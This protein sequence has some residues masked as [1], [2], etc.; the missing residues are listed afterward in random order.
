M[1]STC[2]QATHQHRLCRK[3][4]HPHHYKHR[5]QWSLVCEH[6]TDWVRKIKT[7]T[8]QSSW[9]T[10]HHRLLPEQQCAK[11]KTA[12]ILRACFSEAHGDRYGRRASVRRNGGRVVAVGGRRVADQPRRIA[13]CR[14][15]HHIHLSV[16]HGLHQAL[17][18]PPTVSMMVPVCFIL[19]DFSTTLIKSLK[20]RAWG[21]R[22]HLRDL[23]GSSMYQPLSRTG[24]REAAV[25][26]NACSAAG[27]LMCCSA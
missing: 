12:S 13:P 27:M 21:K 1:Q 22:L 17:P 8:S 11:C 3:M 20:S 16:V 9:C 18:Q 6:V 19:G 23:L 2:V 26:L 14:E 10:R 4:R 7:V 25:A 5:I 24:T 15:G